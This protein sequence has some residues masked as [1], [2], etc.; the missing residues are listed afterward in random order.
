MIVTVSTVF[1]P[2]DTATRTTSV[3]HALRAVNVGVVEASLR[4]PADLST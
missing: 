1:V 2:S 3:F 4:P